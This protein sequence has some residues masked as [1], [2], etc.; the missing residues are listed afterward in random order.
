M[1]LRRF[2][3]AIDTTVFPGVPAEALDAGGNPPKADWSSSSEGLQDWGVY[4]AFDG[5]NLSLEKDMDESYQVRCVR[6]GL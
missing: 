4:F 2:D 5:G 1:D 6:G 3:P